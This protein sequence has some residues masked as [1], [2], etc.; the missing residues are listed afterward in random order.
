MC[1]Y[2]RHLQAASPDEAALVVAAKVLGAMFYRRTLSSVFT[3]ELWPGGSLQECEYEL[4]QVLEFNS[5]RKR[6]SVIV[7]QPNGS[8]R[9][10]CK[11]RRMLYLTEKLFLAGRNAY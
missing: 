3:Q 11:V 9:L 1:V 5:T 8:V 2:E 10:Y 6:Q 4:L 7:R